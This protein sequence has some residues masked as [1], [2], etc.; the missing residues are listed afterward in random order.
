MGGGAG[1]SAMAPARGGVQSFWGAR[2]GVPR[3]G[4]ATAKIKTTGTVDVVA[5]SDRYSHAVADGTAGGGIAVTVM[6]PDAEANGK[7]LAYAGD[8]TNVDAGALNITADGK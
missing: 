3:G 1:T 8:G 7:T 2:N 6:I 5:A 4:D